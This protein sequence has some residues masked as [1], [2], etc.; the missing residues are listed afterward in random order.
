[1][2]HPHEGHEAPPSFWSTRYAIGLLVIGGVCTH[3]ASAIC[4][5]CDDFAWL[6]PAMAHVTDLGHVSNSSSHVRSTGCYGRRGDAI[7]IW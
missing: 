1:M 6:S 3:S 4:S 7:S 5:L 2:E